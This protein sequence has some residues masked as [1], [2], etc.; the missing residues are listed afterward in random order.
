[1]TYDEK[2]DGGIERLIERMS[3]E[4]DVSKTSVLL[5]HE[6]HTT[7]EQV[8]FWIKNARARGHL[9]IENFRGYYLAPTYDSFVRWRKDIVI[10]ELVET[11]D[12]LHAMSKAAKRNF[13]AGE[14]DPD[15][16]YISALE[17]Q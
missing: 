16:L 3:F 12:M 17:V 10:P 9:I 2:V 1:M 6:L 14:H 7:P 8:L 11:L 5:A 4:P 13:S 15:D